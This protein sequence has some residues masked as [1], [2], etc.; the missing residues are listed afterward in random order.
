MENDVRHNPFG[1]RWDVQA[2]RASALS[3]ARAYIARETLVG[4]RLL[5]TP[6]DIMRELR[7]TRN[8]AASLLEELEA[9]GELVRAHGG[10]ALVFKPA[11]PDRPVS[12][13][14]YALD[15]SPREHGALVRGLERLL[16]PLESCPPD[17]VQG[18]VT[19]LREIRRRLK[20]GPR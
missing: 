15:L 16:A 17:Q 20:G 2:D 19:L 18:D 3:D 8:Q 4:E 11:P 6:A 10:Q 12:R 5:I 14:G 1:P 7:T 9:A 13:S